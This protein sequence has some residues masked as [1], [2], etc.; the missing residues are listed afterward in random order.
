LPFALDVGETLGRAVRTRGLTP[1]LAMVIKPNVFCNC[2]ARRDRK[3]GI[4]LSA[5]EWAGTSGVV[6][7]E[8]A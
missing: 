7:P 6:K 2:F 8:G 4:L 3:V 5:S 1:A